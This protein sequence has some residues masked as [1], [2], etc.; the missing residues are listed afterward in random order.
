MCVHRSDAAVQYNGCIVL[1]TLVRN[2]PSNQAAAKAAGAVQLIAAAMRAHRGDTYGV[3]HFG[4]GALAILEP[5]RPLAQL[6]D[7]AELPPPPAGIDGAYR[8][9]FELQPPTADVR[10]LLGVLMAAREPLSVR[11]PRGR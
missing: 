9:W 6:V 3:Q 8:L 10:R 1:A 2:H 11:A 7:T 4:G 5:G